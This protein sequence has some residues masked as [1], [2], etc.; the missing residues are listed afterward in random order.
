MESC[1]ICRKHRGSGPLVGPVVHE[2]DVV[3]VTT[4]RAA[5]SATSFSSPD[6]TWRTSTR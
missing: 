6:V 5:C 1:L 3:V 2:D 4:A